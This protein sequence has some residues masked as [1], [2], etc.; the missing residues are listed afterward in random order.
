MTRRFSERRI[1]A[2][3]LADVLGAAR[4]AP[5]AGF[6][7]GVELLALA[8][9][10]RRERFWELAS[11][12]SWRRDGADAPGLLA[13]PVIV[14]PLADPLAYTSRYAQP[15][16]AASSLSGLDEREWPVPYWLVDASFAAM[17]V[18]LAAGDAGLGGLFFQLHGQPAAL[19][20]G[21]GVPVGRVTI[22]ALALGYPDPAQPLGSASHPPRRARGNLVHLDTFESG[23]R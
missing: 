8:D 10:A 21:L 19:L 3:L 2:G 23:D 17:L 5:S 22:G 18:L 9:P 13:A 15:D 7:Q 14:L 1:E 20:E 4:F 11:E 6:S 16:K 12:A